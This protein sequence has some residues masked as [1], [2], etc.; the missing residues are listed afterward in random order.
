ML[1][2]SPGFSFLLNIHPQR[3]I[4]F[5]ITPDF[6][7]E[8]ILTHPNEKELK[9]AFQAIQ[10]ITL[11][12][13]PEVVLALQ[14]EL[15]K[16]MPD[17]GKVGEVLGTD[18]ALSGLVLKTVNSASYGL[19]RKV[20]SISQAAILLG[21][22]TLRD[23]VLAM[24]LKQALG[25]ESEFDVAL[26]RI[27]KGNA[28]GATAM[29]RSIEGVSVES[30]YLNG[31]FHDAGALILAKKDP[32][33]QELYIHGLSSPV[34]A[35]AEEERRYGTNHV[36]VSFLLAK[37]WELPDPVCSAIYHSHV[38]ECGEIEDP[39]TRTLVA[40]QKVTGSSVS[41]MVF[42]GLEFGDEGARA[43]ASAYTELIVGGDALMEM[44]SKVDGAVW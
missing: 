1:D 18:V 6:I 41:H 38:E 23:V 11:P 35:L 31:L 27:A 44:Y 16:V 28:F 32:D 4:G 22:N 19:P 29:A 43:L 39:E 17:L 21:L 42:P 10:G 30:A 3:P 12:K 26:W 14:Q 15:T 34:S 13:I 5:I 8:I 40:I 9:R 33:Y 2:L 20:E 25:E 24:A 7:S 37:H 36:V